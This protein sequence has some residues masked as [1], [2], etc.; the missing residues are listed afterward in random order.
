MRTYVAATL[1]G[2]SLAVGIPSKGG[3]TNSDHGK[4]LESTCLKDM[5]KVMTQENLDQDSTATVVNFVQKVC[6]HHATFLS[7]KQSKVKILNR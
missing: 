7:R 2:G 6:T 5:N 4:I 3:K 1:C